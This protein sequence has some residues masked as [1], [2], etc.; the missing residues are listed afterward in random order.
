M[1][2]AHILRHLAALTCLLM[3]VA[4]HA[5]LP[6]A[7]RDAVLEKLS[8]DYGESRQSIGLGNNNHVVEVF[9]SAQTGSWTITMTRGDG[10]TCLIASGQ[11]FEQLDEGQPLVGAPL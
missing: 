4:A 1:T 9:A 2:M 5:G 10:M 8:G 3:P 7:P 6:C 11:A